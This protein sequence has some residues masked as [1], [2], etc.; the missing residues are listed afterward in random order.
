LRKLSLRS[1]SQLPE[2][3]PIRNYFNYPSEGEGGAA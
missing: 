3:F 1:Y 2:A